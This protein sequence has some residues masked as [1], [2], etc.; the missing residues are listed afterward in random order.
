VFPAVLV[1]WDEPP[2][3]AR[4]HARALTP[5]AARGPLEAAALWGAALHSASPPGPVLIRSDNEP[6]DIHRYFRL[7]GFRLRR[8]E[9]RLTLVLRQAEDE[10]PAQ[11]ADRWRERIAKLLRRDGDVGKAY[12]RWRWDSYRT[13]H[14]EAPP[15]RQL[16]LVMR[17]Y[18]IVAP[19]R[20][21]PHWQG[22]FTVPVARWQPG[23]SGRSGGAP[24][25]K[26]DPVRERFQ[27]A[28]R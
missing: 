1:R 4:A 28:D 3:S 15:P 7:S 22:P 19:D 10:T 5:L 20:A 27:E 13:A 18:A 21:P 16:I 23:P 26:Y 24:L 14:P 17:R 12:L 11:A 6:P 8:L 25:E 9:G 2:R